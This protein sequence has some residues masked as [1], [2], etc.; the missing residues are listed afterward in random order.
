MIFWTISAGAFL[1]ERTLA[2]GMK[3]KANADGDQESMAHGAVEMVLQDNVF[4]ISPLFEAGRRILYCR[5]DEPP[6]RT[7]WPCSCSWPSA[8]PIMAP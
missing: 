8:N 7:C 1:R 5:H 2:M 4:L 6:P 3:K